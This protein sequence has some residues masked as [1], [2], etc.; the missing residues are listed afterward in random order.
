MQSDFDELNPTLRRLWQY[1]GLILGLVAIIGVVAPYLSD[2]WEPNP[3]YQLPW[4]LL[5]VAALILHETRPFQVC[6][7]GS[8]MSLLM[9]R[10][11][12]Y[13]EQCHAP[14]QTASHCVSAEHW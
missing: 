6:L 4:M 12:S 2:D 14:D 9:Q 11:A 3:L 10:H 7:C 13:P 5:L 1:G 8:M